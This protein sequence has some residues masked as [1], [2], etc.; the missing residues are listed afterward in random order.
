V[1]GYETLRQLAHDRAARLQAEAHAER[2]AREARTAGAEQAA[3]PERRYARRARA[4][5]TRLSA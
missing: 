5:L 1:H 2:M 3:G 4:A